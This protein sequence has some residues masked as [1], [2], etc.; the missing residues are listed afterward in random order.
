M[1]KYKGPIGDR[2]EAILRDVYGIILEAGYNGLVLLYDEFHFLEDGM[3]AHNFPSLCFL[4]P[5]LMFSRRV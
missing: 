1:Q 4:K 5:F 2:L 3:V